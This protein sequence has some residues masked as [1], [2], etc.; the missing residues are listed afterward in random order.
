MKKY[1]DIRTSNIKESLL[2][3][4]NLLK[5]LTWAQIGYIILYGCSNKETITGVG[6]LRSVMY[7]LLK[8]CIFK[9]IKKY[10]FVIKSYN[11]SL[12]LNLSSY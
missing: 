9:T 1:K 5:Y 3:Q 12:S 2:E 10:A 8:T 11:L 6:K 7:F 4:Q